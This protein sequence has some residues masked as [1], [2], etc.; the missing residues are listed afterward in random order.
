MKQ[1][2]SKLSMV[3]RL[4]LSA[5]G[6]MGRISGSYHVPQIPVKIRNNFFLI[7][8]PYFDIECQHFEFNFCLSVGKGR[9]PKP[10]DTKMS[11]KPQ[12]TRGEVKVLFDSSSQ[13]RIARASGKPRP[14][15]RPA[16]NKQKSQQSLLPKRFYIC[17][18]QFPS[19]KSQAAS[20][21]G[22]LCDHYRSCLILITIKG[23]EVTAQG[24]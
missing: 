5:W 2:G 10:R 6:R 1:S 3:A 12:D 16:D 23:V 8:G 18:Q 19:N 11:V 4:E 14:L 21:K 9:P 17:V 24:C 20:K 13:R 15:R 22:L 7:L